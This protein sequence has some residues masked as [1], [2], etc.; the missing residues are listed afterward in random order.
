MKI[1]VGSLGRVRVSAYTL[2]GMQNLINSNVRTLPR[3]HRLRTPLA[4]I[5][6]LAMSVGA[7]ACSST[8]TTTPSAG[9]STTT[10][11]Q[12]PANGATLDAPAFAAA[13]VL[14][15]TVVLD[16]R[17][18]EEFAAGHLTGA[19]NLNVESA[20]FDAQLGALKK[21]VPYAVYC[22]SGNRSGVA[23][24]KMADAGFTAAYHLGGGI[25][26]WQSAGYPVVTGS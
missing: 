16:V 26:A 22:R 24:A 11:A 21:S 19:V 9:T 2:G 18:P 23:L 3:G 5:A 17:T 1:I 7:G 25:G 13:M 20:D 8:S 15:G 6:A 4:V 14:P 10:A 12:A